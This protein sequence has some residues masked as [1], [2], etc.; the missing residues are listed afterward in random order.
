MMN[1]DRTENIKRFVEAI[2]KIYGIGD[3]EGLS[4]T[5]HLYLK[6]ME[7][8]REYR[9]DYRYNG[10]AVLIKAKTPSPIMGA[11]EDENLSVGKV[12]IIVLTGHLMNLLFHYVSIFDNPCSTAWAHSQYI[13]LEE[14]IALS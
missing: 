9:S 10:N 7:A 14:I 2:K 5:I 13:L 3:T 11:F 8:V 6:F 4:D 12:T 1:D